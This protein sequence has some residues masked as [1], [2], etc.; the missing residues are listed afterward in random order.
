MSKVKAVVYESE[1]KV[2]IR[3]VELAPM[4]DTQM[5]AKTL[6]TFVSPGTELRILAGHYG[7]AGKYPLIPGYSTVCEVVEVGSKVKGFRVGDLISGRN[8]APV[9]G[10]RSQWGGQ[11]GGHIYASSGEDK[12]VLLPAGADPLDYVIA[13]VS[14][15][16]L[17]GVE[18]AAPKPGENAVV[19]GQGLIG[20]FSAAWLPCFGCRVVVADMDE[21]RLA[22]ALA[23]GAAAAVDMKEDGAAER[24]RELG[25]GGFDIVVESSGSAAGAMSAYGLVR[26]KPQNYGAD[27]KVEP[28]RFYKPGLAKAG[29]AGQLSGQGVDRP[30]RLHARRGRDD[31][32]PEGP[33]RRGPPEGCRAHPDR[34]DQG[35]RVY[36]P[37]RDAGWHARSVR[38]ASEA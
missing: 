17:R 4:G 23:N 27:Y 8:P 5:R 32:G 26:K 21:R 20:A 28:I 13:E 10:I 29:H 18:A 7:A 14:A 24:L 1:N 22:R 11:A 30:V 36:R 34:A 25:N 2:A 19:I 35:G 37:D 15:I 16:S 12:P 3:E 33:R 31:P 9:P 6:Y 38:Q